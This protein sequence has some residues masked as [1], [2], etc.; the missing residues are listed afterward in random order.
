MRLVLVA[1]LAGIIAVT[2]GVAAAKGSANALEMA[3]YRKPLAEAKRI[4][5]GKVLLPSTFEAGKCWGF[6]DAIQQATGM[7][8][9]SC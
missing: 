3:S 2:S 7:G 8:R 6:F 4:S 5:D 9:R 1:V